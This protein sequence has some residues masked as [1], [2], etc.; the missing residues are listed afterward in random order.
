VLRLA[1]HLRSCRA[2]ED[3]FNRQHGH[4]L[5]VGKTWVHEQ[6]VAH[7]DTV[8][9]MR[10]GMKG[11]PPRVIPLKGHWGL[12]LT[13][14]RTGD[15][16]QQTLGIIDHGSRA[17][18]RLRALPRKC[19]YTLLSEFFAACAEHGIPQSVRT[20][21][22]AMFSGRLW[23]WALGFAGVKHQRIKP[24]CP[25]QNGR[26]ERFFGT[27]KPLLR[28]LVIPSATA[29]QLRLD[30]FSCFYN[31]VRVHQNLGGLTPAE[32]WAGKDADFVR[33]HRG[34]GQWVQALDGLLVGYC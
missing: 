26:I 21:N 30:E 3:A 17:L 23:A 31:H 28:Q 29:L 16:M 33:R 7:A 24:R 11:K 6:L 13:S 10:R 18:I 14:I 12:D 22:E 19:A 5:T 15:G 9:A 34:R 32:A 1:V 8:A 20:D 25:W 4:R 2:I 27:L